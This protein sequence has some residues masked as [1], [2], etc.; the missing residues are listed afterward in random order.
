M[1]FDASRSSEPNDC[2]KAFAL[3]LQPFVTMASWISPFTRLQ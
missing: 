2:V 3:S 1:R